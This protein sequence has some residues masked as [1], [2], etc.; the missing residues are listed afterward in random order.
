MLVQFETP[1]ISSVE[2]P[3]ALANPSLFI[4]RRRWLTPAQGWSAATTLGQNSKSR[5][6][7]KGFGNWRTLSGLIWNLWFDPRV[8]ALLEPWAGVSERLRRMKR[9]GL[10]NAFGVNPGLGLGN[11]FGV[12][13]GL[14][15][16]N[17]FGV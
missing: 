3:K 12:N 2:T 5:P 4:R 11:A 17:A 16:G 14:G 9:L 15:L 13:P 1:R 7:L 6:T 8:L 10:A